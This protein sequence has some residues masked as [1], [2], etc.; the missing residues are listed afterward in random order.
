[1]TVTR[2]FANVTTPCSHSDW[3]AICKAVSRCVRLT[4]STSFS[5]AVHV[6]LMPGSMRSPFFWGSVTG[7]WIC[8]RPQ[9]AA[10]NCFDNNR[11]HVLAHKK[12]EEQEG[13]HAL[14]KLW[15]PMKSMQELKVLSMHK[16]QECKQ[17]IS[18][19]YA[20]QVK[21]QVW[22][23]QIMESDLKRRADIFSCMIGVPAVANSSSSH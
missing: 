10:G 1:M 19:N 21:I 18:W 9:H 14:H 8:R 23:A 15:T 16:Y 12:A 7:Q 6:S 13:S 4:A 11:I 20:Y 3:T 2:A 22:C 17:E 5:I